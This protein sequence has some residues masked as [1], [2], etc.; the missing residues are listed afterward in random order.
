GL[1]IDGE[2]EA[3]VVDVSGEDRPGA[4]GALTRKA[5]DAGVNLAAC[6]AATRSRL[7]LVADDA[8]ALRKAV[9]A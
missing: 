7:V 5:A 6:Y 3:V 9:G 4:L 1:K 8:A 2:R